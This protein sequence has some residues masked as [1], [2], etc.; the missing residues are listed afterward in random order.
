MHADQFVL[1][2][3]KGVQG[4]SGFISYSSTSGIVGFTTASMN[5]VVKTFLTFGHAPKALSF[6]MYALHFD[7][8][9]N[10]YALYV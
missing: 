6:Y 2:S 10:S 3:P 9:V 5:W 1:F 8:L 7:V 4:L